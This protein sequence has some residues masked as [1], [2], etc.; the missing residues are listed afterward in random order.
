MQTGNDNLALNAWIN[1]VQFW[2]I[3]F[4]PRS[5]REVSR[6]VARMTHTRANDATHDANK[7]CL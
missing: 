3:K 5:Y 4:V 2:S 6:A 7:S 1:S